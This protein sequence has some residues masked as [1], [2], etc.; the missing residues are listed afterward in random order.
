MKCILVSEI[1]QTEKAIFCVIPTILKKVKTLLRFKSVFIWGCGVKRDESAEHR[2]LLGSEDLWHC[3]DGI[4][5]YAFIQ[6]HRMYST[7]SK[8]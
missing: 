1:S 2:R 4:C 3:N 7:N 5:Y 8:H 6:I